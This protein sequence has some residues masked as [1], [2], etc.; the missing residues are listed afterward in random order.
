MTAM[1]QGLI[2]VGTRAFPIVMGA[3]GTATDT[4]TVTHD[5]E[6]PAKY[7]NFYDPLGSPLSRLIIVTANDPFTFTFENTSAGAQDVI[8]VAI[9]QYFTPLVGGSIAASDVVLS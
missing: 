7:F 4:G 6:I 5:S 8:C 1:S 9:F 3:N 2:S